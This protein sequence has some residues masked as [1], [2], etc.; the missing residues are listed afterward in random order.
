MDLSVLI[1]SRNEPEISSKE[2]IKECKKLWCKNN[3]E[4]IREYQ[5]RYRN[6]NPK[7]RKD[8]KRKWRENNID[9]VR[10]NRKMRYIKDKEVACKQSRDW[11]FKNKE[12]VRER[13][14]TKKYGTTIEVIENMLQDQNGGCAICGVKFDHV[15]LSVDHNH[16]AGK[17]RGLLCHQCNLAIGNAGDS[18]DRLRAMADYLERYEVTQ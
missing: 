10:A 6:N 4:K 7:K 17:L 2:K 16:N 15:A 14:R 13:I 18:P 3:P 12:M 9:K 1:P 11:Y 5:Q 8:I